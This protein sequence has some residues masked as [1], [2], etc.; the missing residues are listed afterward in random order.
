[1]SKLLGRP[2]VATT[3]VITTA[4]W[5]L[6][7]TDG[8]ELAE[9]YGTA[10]TRG[11]VATLKAIESLPS[12]HS[13]ALDPATVSQLRRSRLED[14]NPAAAAKLGD[15]E[16]ATL[17]LDNTIT[18]A[19]AMIREAAGEPLA[20]SPGDPLAVSLGEPDAVSAAAE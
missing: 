7:P 20:V 1:M 15:L 4:I 16:R 12:V 8:V 9:V 10:L 3:A 2:R 6:L 14:I 18:I 13:A 5:S 11:D 17:D 19:E